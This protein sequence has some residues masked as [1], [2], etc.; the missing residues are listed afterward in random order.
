MNRI[1]KLFSEKK[2]ILSVYFTAGFPQLDST[3]DTISFLAENG[4]DMIEIGIPFSDPLADGP[5]IQQSSK[6]AIENGINA[7]I[8]FEQIKNIRKTIKIPLLIMCY[9]NSILK[10]GFE[11]FCSKAKECGIDG[12]IIPDLPLELVEDKYLQLIHK[13]D[14]DLIFLISPTSSEA[15][16]RKLDSISNSFLYVVS[17]NATTGNKMDTILTEDYFQ[18]IKKMDLKNPF[19]IGF[20][21]SDRESFDTACKYAVGAIIG[22]A[23]IKSQEIGKELDFINEIRGVSYELIGD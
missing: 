1:N 2:K 5:V 3:A 10:Y 21:I 11:K 7:D 19:M 13:Y 15:R 20:G 12:L 14:L 4:V 6:R 22:S 18:R 16:I 8:L 9:S 23:Y 17:S